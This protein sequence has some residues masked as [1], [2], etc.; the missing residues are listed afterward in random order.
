[1]RR[2]LA[3][4][5]ALATACAVFSPCE[6]KAWNDTGH[7]TVALIAY[8]E[9][10][11]SV[12]KKLQEVL[13]KHPHYAEFLTKSIPASANK[14]EW[15]VMK[16]ATWPDW[17]KSQRRE[18]K[19]KY[20]RPDHHYVN[21]PVRAFDGLDA[22]ETQEIEANITAREPKRGKVV[23]SIAAAIGV[24]AAANS[25]AEDKAVELC[26]LLH[27][28][29]DLHQPLHAAALY[30]GLAPKGEMGGNLF[31]V[32]RAGTPTRL[33]ALWDGS[34]GNFRSYPALDELARILKTNV[35]VTADER[36][37][38]DAQKWAEESRSIAEKSAYR[39]GKLKGEVVDSFDD[40]PTNPP[41]LPEEYEVQAREIARKRATLGGLRLADALKSALN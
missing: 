6:A 25:A 27:L 28:V 3:G 26:W 37:V 7:M 8:R 17:V 10:D 30:S 13:K 5:V 39:S 35:H 23:E 32:G 34:L 14:D 4:V 40:E 20:S 29:G 41:P 24:L 12:Q 16:A 22:T 33:H 38:K 18:V 9:V 36:G 31:F 21:L 15:V 1:M 19:N 2:L 11:E